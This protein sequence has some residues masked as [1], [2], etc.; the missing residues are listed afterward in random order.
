MTAREMKPSTVFVMSLK[1][2]FMG[3]VRMNQARA[4]SPTV[5]TAAPKPWRAVSFVT[6][7]WTLSA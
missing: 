2:S 6:A 4:M 1:S 3:F 5:S 7:S